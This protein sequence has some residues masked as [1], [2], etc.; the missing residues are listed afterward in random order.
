MPTNVD[1]KFKEAEEEYL[2][3]K[4]KKEKLRALKKMLAFAPKHKGTEKL[5]A[6]IKIKIKK[7]KEEL[8]RERKAKTALHSP[9]LPI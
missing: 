4:T 2:K 8:K 5:I 3:A 9:T 1:V 7:L 6:E